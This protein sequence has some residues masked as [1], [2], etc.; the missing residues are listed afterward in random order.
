MIKN[1]KKAVALEYGTNAVPKVTAK[2]SEE[3]SPSDN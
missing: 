3:S 1:E 2:G